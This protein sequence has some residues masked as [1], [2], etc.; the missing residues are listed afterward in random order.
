MVALTDGG[1]VLD[2]RRARARARLARSDAAGLRIANREQRE[3][4]R[5]LVGEVEEVFARHDA[6]ASGLGTWPYWAPP[7]RE[8]WTVLVSVP[9]PD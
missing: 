9:A 5:T 8:L 1:H 3:A 4:R 7:S 6:I 2:S